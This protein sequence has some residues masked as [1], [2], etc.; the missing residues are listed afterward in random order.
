[1]S[2][3]K[4]TRNFISSFPYQ[5]LISLITFLNG[6]LNIALVLF[7]RIP[8]KIPWARFFPFGVYYW[9]RHLTLGFGFL[10]IYLSFNL[11]HRKR[12]AWFLTFLVLLGTIF[13]D[14]FRFHHPGFILAPAVTLALLIAFRRWFKVKSEISSIRRGFFWALM[15]LLLALIYGLIG[16]ILMKQSDFGFKLNFFQALERVLRQFFL[17]GNPDLIPHSKHASWFLSSLNWL[18]ALSLSYV[19]YSLFRPLTYILKTQPHEKVLAK[20]ISEKYAQEPLDFFKLAP[21]K[22]LFFTP[23]YDSFI[24]YRTV[25]HIAFSL[26]DPLGP[27]NKIFTVIQ[28]FSDFCE[29]NG[30]MPA[31]HQ[32]TSKYLETYEKLGFKTLKIGEEAKVDL[33]R[34]SSSTINQKDFRYYQNKF[35][36]D[37]FEVKKMNP[38]HSPDLL[39]K[40]EKISREW[41]TLPGRHEQKFTLGQFDKNYL[42]QTTLMVLFDQEN[43]PLAFINLIPVF[44][45]EEV[46]LDL[47]RHQIT[48]PNGAMDYL[49]AQTMLICFQEGFK[50]FDLGLAP[51]SGTGEKN[52]SPLEEKALQQIYN[53]F[54]QVFS[55][56]GLR[57][58]KEKF[59]PIWENRYLAYRGG[60]SGLAKT[61]LALKSLI[62]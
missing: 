21:D 48:I 42:N 61:A 1:M 51:L 8:R 16:F 54:N 29:N 34:F 53:R 2:T 15:S 39:K 50:K 22:S 32:I 31:F 44:K 38:P 56:K 27:K 12:T 35:K 17:L 9:S 26:G 46:G 47:M 24:A 57:S 25:N 45:K 7:S 10:L 60:P 43:R 49:L 6:L 30:W 59:E 14:L 13:L 52:E 58:F 19:I 18:G 20:N 5:K 4:K 3:A 55:F 23:K 37:G 40:L 41:L 28:L 33:A 62:N 36:K 11:Y